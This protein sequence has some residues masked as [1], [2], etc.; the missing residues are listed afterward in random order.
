[1]RHRLYKINR[2]HKNHGMFTE[3]NKENNFFLKKNFEFCFDS[4]NTGICVFE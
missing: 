1:M 4:I 2:T 3:I